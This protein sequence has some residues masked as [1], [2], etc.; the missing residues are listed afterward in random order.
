MDGPKWNPVLREGSNAS[1][2]SIA[3][4]NILQQGLEIY[5]S[6]NHG[7]FY[8]Q[9]ALP[10]DGYSQLSIVNNL[11]QT[12]WEKELIMQLQVMVLLLTLAVC[13]RVYM[14]LL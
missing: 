2:S 10:V 5:P 13:Q 9:F 11:N 12:V 8:L 1:Q 14:L 3:N 4:N 7:N 6:P